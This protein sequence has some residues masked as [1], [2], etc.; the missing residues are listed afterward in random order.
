MAAIILIDIDTAHSYKYGS[1]E[2][3][4]KASKQLSHFISFNQ[5][6]YFTLRLWLF[7][8]DLRQLPPRSSRVIFDEL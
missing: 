3:R 6:N 7:L 1:V 8:S 5:S 4:L 2:A